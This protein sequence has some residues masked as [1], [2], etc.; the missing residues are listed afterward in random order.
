MATF[1]TAIALTR[2]RLSGCSRLLLM[3]MSIFM[4]SLLSSAQANTENR[5]SASA[6]SATSAWDAFLPTPKPVGEGQFR[7]WGFLIYDATLWS[8][9]G[10]YKANEPFALRL[11]Y[12]RNVTRDQIVDA[13]IDQM[14][15]LGVDV[16]QHPDWPD[17]LQRVFADVNKGDSLT[18]IYMPGNGAVFFYN[19]QLTGQVDEA[20]AQAFFSIWLDPQTTEPDLRLSLLG[21]AQ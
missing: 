1:S 10:Q 18:G 6:V 11:S 4:L 9:N 7:R 3:V 20:L 16:A 21:L 13:S 19:N 15:E 14:R 17:K 8:S 12:A 5:T 2:L